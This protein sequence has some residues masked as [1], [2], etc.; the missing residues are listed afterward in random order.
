[1]RQ[2]DDTDPMPFGKFK[3]KPMSEVDASYLHWLWIGGY[4]DRT[5]T[6]NVANYIERNLAALKK[7]HP[8]GI[9]E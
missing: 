2:L 7:E 9:W 1:M 5:R 4:K 3:G 8:D 6:S